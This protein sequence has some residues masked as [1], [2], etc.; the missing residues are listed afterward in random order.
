MTYKIFTALD[1]SEVAT[2]DI[3]HTAMEGMLKTKV[4]LAFTLKWTPGIV[5]ALYRLHVRVDGG[6][7]HN[8][9]GHVLSDIDGEITAPLGHFPTG[10]QLEIAFGAQAVSAEIPRMATFLVADGTHV[11]RL[12]P[13]DSTSFKKL[14]RLE[15]WEESGSVSLP[16]AH[17]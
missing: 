4:S 9:I 6:A 17:A 5:A 10:A 7:W 13:P 16:G 15:Y 3:L 2:E 1:W 14:G 11:R 12:S 8:A